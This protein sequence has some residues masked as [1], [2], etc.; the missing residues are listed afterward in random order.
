VLRAVPPKGHPDV[1]EED[2]DRSVESCGRAST[3]SASAAEIRKQGK[4]QIS[5]QLPGI[6]D[7]E[8]RLR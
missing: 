6:S 3:S 7:P 5:V 4:D 2:M 1:T 8:Q